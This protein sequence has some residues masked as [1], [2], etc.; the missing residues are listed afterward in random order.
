MDI[1]R[2]EVLN[3]IDKRPSSV[4]GTTKLILLLS[5]IDSYLDGTSTEQDFLDSLKKILGVE[6]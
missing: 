3:A 2:N 5:L 6:E 1:F 4:Y